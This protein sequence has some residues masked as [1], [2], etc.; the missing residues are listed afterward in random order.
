MQSFST[1]R[2]Q[3]R[4]RG[5]VM[6]SILYFIP[7][8]KGRFIYNGWHSKTIIGDHIS[9]EGYYIGNT[10]EKKNCFIF[11]GKPY[12]PSMDEVPA[13]VDFNPNPVG[14]RQDSIE[15]FMVKHKQSGGYF[16][17]C[18]YLLS[19]PVEDPNWYYANLLTFKDG[20]WQEL[21]FPFK[22]IRW[23]IGDKVSKLWRKY[24]NYYEEDFE[25]IKK[26]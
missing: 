6:A 25:I 10:V 23:E 20:K 21:Q 3:L 12:I 14:I 18:R 26:L 22:A 17:I 2:K 8:L 5:I 1:W 9:K 11:Y 7:G 4:K 16:V 24:G 15:Y 13:K 19:N